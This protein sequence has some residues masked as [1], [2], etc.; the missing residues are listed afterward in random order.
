MTFAYDNNFQS[1]ISASETPSGNTTN[2]LSFDLTN[3][4]PFSQE[5]IEITMLNAVPPTLNGGENLTF[6]T[7]VTP[8][9][10]IL[11]P[12]T[13]QLFMTKLLSI[14]LTPMINSL[15]KAMKLQMKTKTNI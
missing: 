10:M 4:E 5:V 2:L 11:I 7:Q 13:I 14:R 6:T 8:D 1:F 15:S 3:L 9:L 12:M